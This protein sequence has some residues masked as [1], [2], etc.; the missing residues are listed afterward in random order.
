MNK[1]KSVGIVIPIYNEDR[2][3]EELFLRLTKII[4]ILP[5]DFT[6]VVVD[7]GS[8]DQTLGLL[9][10][11]QSKEK[12]LKIIKLSRNWWARLCAGFRKIR[13]RRA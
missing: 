10:N 13:L 9:R 11:I 8:T 4:D 3:V 7:D 6:I 5:Y 1:K 2:I 12:R